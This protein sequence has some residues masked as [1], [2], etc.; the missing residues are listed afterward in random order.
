[1]VNLH[2]VIHNLVYKTKPAAHRANVGRCWEVLDG[3][4]LL[5]CRLDPLHGDL[6]S[7]ELDKSA[8]KLELLR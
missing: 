7:G 1:M 2:E 3:G 6:E 5:V 8:S 4:D